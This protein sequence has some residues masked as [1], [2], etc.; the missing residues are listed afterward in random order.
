M[1]SILSAY[2]IYLSYPVY[3]IQG[4]HYED[5]QRVPKAS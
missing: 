5:N 2:P 1:G 3:P 4:G